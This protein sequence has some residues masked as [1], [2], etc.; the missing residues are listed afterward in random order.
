MA[1]GTKRW[2]FRTDMSVHGP[3]AVADEVVYAQRL[4]STLYALDAGSGR[5]LWK[6]EP[7]GAPEP[8]NQRSNGYYGVTV[9]E[10]KVF[11]THQDRFGIGSQGVIAAL[12]PKSGETIWQSP[13]AG[14]HDE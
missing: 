10:G 3:I 14:G 4:R 6:R 7:E 5:L 8:N 1:T 2:S 13:M 12:E 9:A 11:W